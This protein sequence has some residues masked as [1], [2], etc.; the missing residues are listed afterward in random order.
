[1][2]DE[3]LRLDGRHAARRDDRHRRPVPETL[4]TWRAFEERFGVEVEVAGRQQPGQPWTGP[5]HCCGG[6]KV[7]A[8]ERALA[9]AEALDHRHP[10]RAGPDARAT[11]SRS[12]ATTSAACGS[13]TRSPT[14]PSKDLWRR[15]HERDLPYHPLHDQRLRVDRLR[16]VHAARAPAARAAG[17]APTRPSAASTLL[18]RTE[19]RWTRSSSSSASA[20]ASSSA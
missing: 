14:G 1:M 19:L 20:S 10:P 15:I 16:A 18:Q 13:T 12:S 5:E 9:G 8:L 17:P 4:E 7:A 11:P 6:A 2:L 3:L